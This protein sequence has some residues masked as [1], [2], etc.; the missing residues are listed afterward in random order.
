MSQ[1]IEDVTAAARLSR[2]SLQPSLFRREHVALDFRNVSVCTQS[3]L[4]ALLYET[5]R[6]S[7]GVQT[8]VFIE[9]AAPGVVAGVRLVDNYARGG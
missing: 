1:V 3:F 2:E 6:I 5:I 8:P 4:H 7:W 9:N